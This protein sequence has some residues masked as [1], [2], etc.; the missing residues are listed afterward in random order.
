[1]KVKASNGRVRL[2]GN[3]SKDK[4]R[5]RNSHLQ[6]EEAGQPEKMEKRDVL[7]SH[8]M[9]REHFLCRKKRK[10]EMR[11]GKKI[12]TLEAEQLPDKLMN[13]TKLTHPV[14]WNA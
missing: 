7:N 3:N 9:K 2:G 13:I 11:E 8:W 10:S 1:M 4:E 5:K 6:K 12:G 14:A